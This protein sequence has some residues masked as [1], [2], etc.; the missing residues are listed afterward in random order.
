MEGGFKGK[1]GFDDD[2]SLEGVPAV[3]GEV[4]GCFLGG[5]VVVAL[6][7]WQYNWFFSFWTHELCSLHKI[8]GSTFHN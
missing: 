3:S 5:L 7:K 1:D 8:H 4:L 6:H 2:A